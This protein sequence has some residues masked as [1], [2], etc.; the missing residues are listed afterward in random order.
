MLYTFKTRVDYKIGTAIIEIYII[1][2][3]LL[4]I[5]VAAVHVCEIIKKKIIK[6]LSIDALADSEKLAL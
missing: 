2:V 6:K 5:I 1:A 4:E 3:S